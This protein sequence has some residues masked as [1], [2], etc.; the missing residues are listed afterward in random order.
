MANKIIPKGSYVVILYDPC[1]EN[2]WK[3]YCMKQG[4]K[5]KDITPVS[6]PNYKD[7]IHEDD[8]QEYYYV[9]SEM[10]WRYATQE[11]IDR[12]E[13]EGLYKITHKPKGHKKSKVLNYYEIF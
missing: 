9:S 7:N 2:C 11:E 8:G 1:T 5:G 13:V 4:K 3:N 10:E 6:T 12:Y